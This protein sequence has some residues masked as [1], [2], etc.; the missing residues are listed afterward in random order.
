MRDHRHG[1]ARRRL[2]AYGPTGNQRKRDCHRKREAHERAGPSFLSWNRLHLHTASFLVSFF[3]LSAG[4]SPL[5][6]GAA[7]EEELLVTSLPKL[8][9]PPPMVCDWNTCAN[10]FVVDPAVV[11]V[12]VVAG[13]AEKD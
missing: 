7:L 11:G 1:V 10:V 2:R 8:F 5:G 12:V 9:S 4:L 6:V 13:G 3:A